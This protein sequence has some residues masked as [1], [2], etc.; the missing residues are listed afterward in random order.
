MRIILKLPVAFVFTGNTTFR[1]KS[2]FLIT[3]FFY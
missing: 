2:A 3:F 1:A